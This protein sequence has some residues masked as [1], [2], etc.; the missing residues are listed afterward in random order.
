MPDI[1]LIGLGV[2]GKSLA[3]NIESKGYTLSVYNKESDWTSDFINT[4]A[5][6]KNIIPA[7]S[8]AELV[9]QQSKPRKIMLMIKAGEPVDSVLDELIGLLDKG[10]IVIDGGN[11]NYMDTIRRFEK[12]KEIGIS[13][14]GMGISGGEKGAL[15]GPSLMA[16]GQKDAWEEVRPIFE[17]ISAHTSDN[18]PCCQL[19]G[20]NGA[21][22]FVK[23]VH[24]GIEYADMQLIGE[25][26]L[27]MKTLLCLSYEEIAEVFKKWNNGILKSYLLNITIDILLYKDTDSEPLLDKIL[28]CAGQKGTGQW[29][30]V[31]ALENQVPAGIITEAIFSRYVSTL[32]SERI[33]ANTALSGADIQ[34]E[35]DTENLIKTL[36]DALLSARI[37]LYSQGFSLIKNVSLIHNWDIDCSKVAFVWSEGCIIKSRLLKNMEKSL[38]DK[39][40]TNLLF[41][42][43]FKQTLNSTQ[44]SLRLI[45]AKTA[46][47]GIPSPCFSSALSYYDSYRCNIL[48]ANLIQAQRDYFGA[49]TYQR[50]D[51]PDN[52]N[53]HTHWEQN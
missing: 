46:L 27:I 29:T 44:Q 47:S 40:L 30:A 14:I 19:L 5:G 38:E 43:F 41:S 28:D 2:M 6:G 50:I 4:K 48:P 39:I 9:A 8:L 51:D 22:H 23:M 35:P 1:A 20:L 11:S 24:N 15:N 18:K 7:Y 33:V 34:K 13:Y 17:D 3:L 21:G 42:D 25:A 16:G 12:L 32:K 37:L 53:H 45:C 52:K 31:T 10:D 36:E 49:H 26:Y